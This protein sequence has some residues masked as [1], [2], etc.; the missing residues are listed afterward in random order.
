MAPDLLSENSDIVAVSIYKTGATE[1]EKTFAQ[2]RFLETYGL[3]KDF[4]RDISSLSPIP[5][6]EILRN[7]EEI[8][9]ASAEGGPPMIGYGRLVVMQ[10]ERGVPVEQWAVIGFVRLD[11]S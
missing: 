9:N 3:N 8:W 4:F 11:R 6:A 2:D 1:P 7:G 5:F 10:D